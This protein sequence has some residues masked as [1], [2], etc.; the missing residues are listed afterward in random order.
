MIS[1]KL[2]TGILL[3]ALAI[4]SIFSP[5]LIF[6]VDAQ[7]EQQT[8]NGISVSPIRIQRNYKGNDKDIINF[9]LLNNEDTDTTLSVTVRSFKLINNNQDISF[10]TTVEETILNWIRN[11]KNSIFLQ[12]KEKAEY[13]LELN[14]GGDTKPGGYL[15]AIFFET[16]GKDNGENNTEALIK[17][18][19]GVPLIINVVGVA[20]IS[21]GEI[22][23]D[24]FD[25][26]YNIF[27]NNIQ[28]SVTILNNSNQIIT[29]AGL[30]T[31]KK[32]NGL[33]PDEMTSSFNQQDKI[34][35]SFSLRTY[36]KDI[37]LENRFVV[38]EYEVTLNF[39]YGLENNVFTQKTRIWI[40]PFWI[41]ILICIIIFVIYKASRKRKLKSAD[42]D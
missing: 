40:I 39:L 29:P 14:I 32:L 10:D 38:G 22:S 6:K 33:G 18:S 20:G 13:N 16:Q 15:F 34:I 28:S 26:S 17:Q 21:Y 31:I 24:T 3:G 8:V 23:I 11:F 4:L 30:F 1:G 2:F 25:V 19:I 12:P 41:P 7:V 36:D 35:N 9:T 42:E 5:K 37:A 27:S